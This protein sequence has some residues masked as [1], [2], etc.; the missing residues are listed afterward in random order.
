MVKRT[1]RDFDDV[2]EDNIFAIELPD[3]ALEV[4]AG[5]GKRRVSELMQCG[6]LHWSIG[7]LA[8]K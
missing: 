3:E 8:L 4:S 7:L 1:T 5:T 2:R 6:S